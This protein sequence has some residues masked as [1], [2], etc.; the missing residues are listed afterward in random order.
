MFLS[1]SVDLMKNLLWT[2]YWQN[3]SIAQ[4]SYLERF[5]K[6]KIARLFPSFITASLQK[7][8]IINEVASDF[9]ISTKLR[10]KFSNS[11]FIFQSKI[12]N[13]NSTSKRFR[14]QYLRLKR[15]ECFRK[16][17]ETVFVSD[18]FLRLRQTMEQFGC[19]FCSFICPFLEGLVHS[20]VKLNW[21]NLFK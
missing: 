21:L 20:T 14:T 17:C 1:Y 12:S 5:T 11:Y 2:G 8:Q 3:K 7:G 19:F 9:S 13:S 16:V 6:K 10:Y 15:S 18:T 4:F